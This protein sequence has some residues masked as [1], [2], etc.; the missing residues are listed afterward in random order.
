MIP[1]EFGDDL[2]VGQMI[3][4]EEKE[5][6]KPVVKKVQTQ[7][8]KPPKS[9]EFVEAGSED[10]N[11]EKQESVK[12]VKPTDPAKKEALKSPEVLKMDSQASGDADVEDTLMPMSFSIN[13]SLEVSKEGDSVLKNGIYK[14]HKNHMLQNLILKKCY[15]HQCRQTNKRGN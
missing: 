9:T 14:G 11:D 7:L 15:D 1:T 5:T 3:H 4:H 10:S 6:E 2:S 8:K 12:K 13:R